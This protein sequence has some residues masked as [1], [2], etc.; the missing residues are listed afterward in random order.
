MLS[1]SSFPL[2]EQVRQAN[3]T[4]LRRL[5]GN[6]QP[7]RAMDIGGYDVRHQH[8]D[9]VRAKKLLDRLIAPETIQLKVR[10][11]FTPT[12]FQLTSD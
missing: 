2:R 3:E 10:L 9:L 7:F 8:I 4:R 1:D 11:H 6:A 12:P 5:P